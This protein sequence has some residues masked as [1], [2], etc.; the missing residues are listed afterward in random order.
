MVRCLATGIV[1]AEEFDTTP[2]TGCR[3]GPRAR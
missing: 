3:M 1:R 2:A